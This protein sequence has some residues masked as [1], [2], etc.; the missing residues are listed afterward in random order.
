MRRALAFDRDSIDTSGVL[1]WSEA[2][3][4]LLTAVENSS[5]DLAK[6]AFKST[7]RHAS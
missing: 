7:Q 3:D 4:R 1:D 5:V 6:T 2:V